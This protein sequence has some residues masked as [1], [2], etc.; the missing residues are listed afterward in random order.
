[1]NLY[2]SGVR[3]LGSEICTSTRCSP[4]IILRLFL[5]SIE[6]NVGANRLEEINQE[7]RVFVFG[8]NVLNFLYVIDSLLK[9]AN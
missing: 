5:I 8:L 9:V 7:K 2:S 3:E 1:M 6:V 4:R